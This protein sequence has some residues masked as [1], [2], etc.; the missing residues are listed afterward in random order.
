V[1]ALACATPLQQLGF[2]T[3]VCR[4]SQR[5]QCGME[6]KVDSSLLARHLTCLTRNEIHLAPASVQGTRMGASLPWLVEE[7]DK[8]FSIITTPLYTLNLLWNLIIAFKRPCWTIQW[9]DLENVGL[10]QKHHVKIVAKCL[11]IVRL[12]CWSSS[13]MLQLLQHQLHTTTRLP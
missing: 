10:E 9:T 13:L 4:Y 2:K 1:N 7:N 6:F 8:A 3:L 12:A 11:Q 5:V